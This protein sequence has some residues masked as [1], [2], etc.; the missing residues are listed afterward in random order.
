MPWIVNKATPRLE[1]FFDPGLGNARMHATLPT[2]C[3]RASYAS[4]LTTMLRVSQ[5]HPDIRGVGITFGQEPDPE[6]GMMRVFVQRVREGSSAAQVLRLSGHLP[7]FVCASVRVQQQEC[8]SVRA[9]PVVCCCDDVLYAA[10]FVICGPTT[11]L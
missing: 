10:A 3:M 5:G 9:K 4:L 8:L 6:T 7:G 11:W 2:V 1:V